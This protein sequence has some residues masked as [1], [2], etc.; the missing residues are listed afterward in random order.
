MSMETS[1]H[2]YETE[3]VDLRWQPEP[4]WETWPKGHDTDF[5]MWRME[6][7]FADI[8]V[9]GRGGT[10]LDVACGNAFHAPEMHEAGWQ[11]YGI[12]PSPEMLVRAVAEVREKG[13][14]IDM[15]RGIGEVLPFRD[16][17]FD[18][19]V[20][21][22]SI[23]HFA[24]P[25]VGMREMGRILKPGGELIIGFTNYG[26]LSVRLSRI[27]YAVRRRLGLVAKGKRLFWDDPTEGEHTF[28]GKMPTLKRFAGPSLR[29]HQAYGVSMLWAVPGWS[30]VLGLIPGNSK[31]AR[32]V[33]GGIL[34]AL[35]ALAR[36]FPSQADFLVLTWKRV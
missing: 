7:A 20:C 19:V 16:A 11:V 33:R 6:R 8:A 27:N 17:T 2:P 12:D 9:A 32:K 15:F 23:D 28:E 25:D 1:A 26:S 30:F 5:I 4:L 35:D 10:L 13:A 3:Q 18:R 36:R 34:R 24:N 21:M 22:S 14:S 29:L 31:P